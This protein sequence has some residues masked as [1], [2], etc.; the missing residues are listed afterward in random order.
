M[1]P[2]L[3]TLWRTLSGKTPRPNGPRRRPAC[4]RLCLEV[5]EDR[6]VPA[7]LGYSTYLG[8]SSTAIYAVAADSSGN[9]YVA[10][11]DSSGVFAA[12][13]NATGTALIYYT[14][15]G[16]ATGLHQAYGIAVDGAGDAYVVGQASGVPTTANAFSQTG[17][18]NNLNSGFVSVLNPTGG[19]IYSTY[20][21]GVD[22]SYAAGYGNVWGGIAVDGAG[23]AYVTGRAGPGLP[24]TSGAYQSF[25]KGSSGEDNAFL[26]KI[27]PYLSGTASLVYCSYLGGSAPNSFGDVGTG[28]AV[29]SAGN[30]YLSGFT[31]SPDFPFTAGAYQTSPGGF[32]VAKMN[33][34]LS[35]NAS[36]LYS[37][38]L[39]TA[40][41]GYKALGYTATGSFQQTKAPAIAVDSAGAAYVAGWTDTGHALVP[42]TLGAYDTNIGSGGG[43][44]FVTK[45]NPSGSQL[46][47]STYLGINSGWGSPTAAMGIA[48]DSA[49]NAHVT[50]VTYTNNFPTVNPIQT[51]L[52]G[53]NAA[54]V[55]TVNGTGSGLL[56]STYLGGT[57]S[58][59][60]FGI[61]M[62]PAGNTYVAGATTC[63]DFPITPGA[64]QS[65]FPGGN[66]GFVAKINAASPSFAVT[67]FPS[68]T[69]A[70]TAG[71]FTVTAQDANGNTL[72]GYTGT[73]HFT[74]SDPQAILP[75]DYTFTAADQG[76]HTFSATLKT[77]G[78]Q[79][80]VA[81]DTVTSSLSG[82]AGIVVNPSAATHFVLSGPSGVSAGTAFS[83]TV[84]AVDAY[85]NIATG[86]TGTVHFTDSVSGA[87][88]PH[89]Y[90]FTATDAGV[91]TFSGVKLRTKGLETITVIDMLFA[92]ISGSIS[93]KVS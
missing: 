63:S 72:T 89:D 51:Q 23:N 17:G 28:I 46:V 19:L 61:A 82:Q 49:G 29:D 37:T 45:L 4:R 35:G 48:V 64:S 33:P 73:V 30:A 20:L 22:N 67:G 90:T 10:G 16:N 87:T 9:A 18:T 8:D 31:S 74:S 24:T 38:Y 84:T 43:V 79:S 53:A 5:L 75:A 71:T 47:Y 91:H 86:Y 2:T 65:T 44:A 3:F 11:R 70:G 68:P 59:M 41:G 14:H 88:L 55:T 81:T 26:A 27:D 78:S 66:T 83:L 52:R 12:K 1:W 21:P 15:L 13:L 54:F 77:A 36:L 57:S 62:D 7:A 58:T 80:L 50:G 56:F 25:L 92:S 69:T 39:G 42:A 40:G 34:S 85:G 76:V 32:F 93:I 60:G 6:A